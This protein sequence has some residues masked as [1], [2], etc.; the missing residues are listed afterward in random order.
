MRLSEVR[1]W[2]EAEHFKGKE[3]SQIIL[4][5]WFI[6][7]HDTSWSR[8]TSEHRHGVSLGRS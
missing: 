6:L 5:S 1:I 4:V 2:E 7:D 8:L 3:T